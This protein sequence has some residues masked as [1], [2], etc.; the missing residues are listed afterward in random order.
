[1][2]RVTGEANFFELFLRGEIPGVKNMNKQKGTSKKIVIAKE[3]RLKQSP[4]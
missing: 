3:E 1:M 2:N 4:Q